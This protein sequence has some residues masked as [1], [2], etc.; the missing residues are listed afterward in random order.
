MNI[1]FENAARCIVSATTR[2]GRTEIRSGNIAARLSLRKADALRLELAEVE[3]MA[4]TA[5]YDDAE[6]Q[7][8]RHFLLAR[9]VL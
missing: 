8:I 1:A 4:S 3:S 7:A 2:D 9:H 5:E 6:L